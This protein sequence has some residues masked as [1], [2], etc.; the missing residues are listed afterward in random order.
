MVSRPKSRSSVSICLSD[1][2]IAGKCLAGV[3]SGHLLSIGVPN[4]FMGLDEE[5][6]LDIGRIG[7]HNWECDEKFYLEGLIRILNI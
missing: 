4:A 2:D 5:A 7:V 1:V 3:S 6:L